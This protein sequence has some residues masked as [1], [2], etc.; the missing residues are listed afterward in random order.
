MTSVERAFMTEGQ[1]RP[2][3]LLASIGAAALL[4][5]SSPATAAIAWDESISGDLADVGTAATPVTFTVG[6][7]IVQGASGHDQTG[8]IDRDYFTFT[9]APDE[10]L[11]AITILPGTQTLG[12][13]FLGLQ[14]GSQVTLPFFPADAT[15][16]LGWVHYNSTHIGTDVLDDMSVSNLATPGGASGFS[17]PL[18]PGTYAVW[19][20]EISPGGAVPYALDFAVG[21]VPE[22]STWAMMLAGFGLLG[23]AF[24]RKRKLEAQPI[25]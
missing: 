10:Y 4:A 2:L 14:S 17:T 8:A 23:L 9:L 5:V 6:S 13:S 11:S 7:N 15:G 19:L 3:R 12:K 16:L 1:R 25:G 22:P 20:Q 21:Q 18:G 24:R